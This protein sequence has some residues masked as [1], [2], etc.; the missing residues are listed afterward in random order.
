M[1]L[2]SRMMAWFRN[3]N[4]KNRFEG[5]MDE[6][7]QFHLESMAAENIR[8]GMTPE[9]ARRRAKIEFGGMDQIKEG[10]RD[11]RWTRWMDQLWQDLRFGI[12]MMRKSPQLTVVAVLA[13]AL[14]IG[15]NSAIFS[16]VNGI[17]LKPLPYPDPSRLVTIH[18]KQIAHAI[19][20]AELHVIRDQCT[21]LERI[22]TYSSRGG[23]LVTGGTGPR[24][25]MAGYVSGDFFPIMGVRPLLGRPI[26]PEDTQPGNE[27]VAVLSHGLWMEQFGGDTDIVGKSISVNRSPYVVIGVMPR[28]FG[29]GISISYEV[30]SYDGSFSA[31]WVPQVP[32]SEGDRNSG[33]SQIVARLKQDATLTQANAQ[34]QPMSE[35]FA[36]EYPAIYREYP[37]LAEESKL[38]ARSLDLVFIPGVRTRLWILFGAV[39]FVLL[40][41][42]VN[43]ASLLVAR[44]WIRE[45]ELGIRK[46]LGA[47][48]RRILRQFLTES[49][50]L[51]LLGGGMGLFLSFL[52][53]HLLRGIAPPYTPRVD[54]I[55]LDGN[56]LWFTLGVSL[57]ATIIIGLA[58]AFQAWS[59]GAGSMMKGGQKGA[60]IET[61]M[62]RPHPL[63]NALIVLEVLLAFI[64][65]AGGSLMVRSFSK[66][67]SVN[68]GIQPGPVLTLRVRFSDLVAQEAEGTQRLIVARQV[69]DG[70]RSIPGVQRAA[71]SVGG[72]ISGGGVINKLG[73]VAPYPGL[74]YIGLYIEG[75]EGD[76][77][78]IVRQIW[79]RKITPEFFDALGIRILRGRSFNAEDSTNPVAVVSEDLAR[80][81]IPGDPLG[82][83]FSIYEGED[84]S[85][86]WMEVLGV[87]NNVRDHTV[88]KSP[89]PVFYT[90]LTF[91]PSFEFGI[92][93]KTSGNPMLHFPA[94]KDVVWSADREAEITNVRTLDQILDRSVAES[95]FQTMLVGLLGIF[96]LI[97]AVIGI[98]GVISYSV[99]HR[100]HEIGVRMAL[101][102]RRRDVMYLILKEGMLLAIV[103]IAL[104]IGG[105]LGLTRVLRSMLFEIEPTD[106]GTFIG[107]AIVLTIASLAACYIPARRATK[108]DPMVTLRH[109]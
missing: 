30:G 55:Q 88:V 15:A 73:P 7:L 97:L 93:V 27:H 89:D 39:G 21:A 24:Q 87:V 77:L 46:A 13:L 42:C 44:I 34:L 69:L 28:E 57:L 43:V 36:A 105:A 60:L 20:P 54:F 37:D 86:Q 18:R 80:R 92:S 61:S 101:G 9:D 6:E 49:L 58:P 63:R 32:L 8:N 59:K 104:G 33:Y 95:R 29:A 109:E 50:L 45:K 75:L 10:C 85:H 35:S 83:Q 4:G 47:T 65:V 41:A 99:I 91:I 67:M 11:T 12:R 23:H 84:G 16:A 94:I 107:V 64:L 71:L 96:G 19:T 14:G 82:K 78:S 3:C 40:L 72:P 74:G 2:L 38:Y 100:T 76:Q 70:I 66:L 98:Y 5:E 31:M 1:K 79:E 103:G 90:P 17:L 102:A 108:V 53:T 22:A 68:T 56:V 62:K 51:A 52:G 48:R 25:V 26:I 81:C 106:P